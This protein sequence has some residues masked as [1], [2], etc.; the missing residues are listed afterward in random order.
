MTKG[1]IFYT[2]NQ[3]NL[4]LAHAVQSTI[5]DSHLPITSCSLKP[6]DKM[7]TNYHL[8][9]ERGIMTM[10]KQILTCLENAQEEVVFFCEADVLYHPSHFDFEPEDRQMF[11]Y[12]TNWWSVGR[13]DKAVTWDANRVS[14]LCCFREHALNYYRERIKEIEANGFNRSYEPGGRDET[15]YRRWTSEVANIDVLHGNNLTARK[16]SPKDFRDKSTGQNFQE[17][18]IDNIPGWDKLRD[19]L[20][21]KE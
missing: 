12:N 10:F 18:T 11:Y 5:R 2:D 17:T 15:K 3:V 6:M 7:G 9:A 20:P 8:K 21:V 16:W 19:I 13:G 14:Q 4:K 1:I